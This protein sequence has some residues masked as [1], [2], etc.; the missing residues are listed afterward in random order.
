MPELLMAQSLAFALPPKASTAPATS[1]AQSILLLILFLL[2]I[3]AQP[4]VA[5]QQPPTYTRPPPLGL[6]MLL[7]CLRT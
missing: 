1:K 7:F 3:Y 5:F 6:G 2:L 4:G